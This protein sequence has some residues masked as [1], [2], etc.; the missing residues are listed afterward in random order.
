MDPAGERLAEWVRRNGGYIHP[1]L[2]V[3]INAPTGSRGVVARADIPAD[4]WW[5]DLP[6]GLRDDDDADGADEIDDDGSGVDGPSPA[7]TPR[8]A[9]GSGDHDDG[10]DPSTS[11]S[12]SAAAVPLPPRPT[13]PTPGTGRRRRQAPLVAVPEALYLSNALLDTG[14]YR[15]LLRPCRGVANSLPAHLQLALVL[16][17]EAEAGPRSFWA[18]Y[19]DVLRDTAP[20]CGW[21]A[22]KDEAERCLAAAGVPTRDRERE[23]AA[24]AAEAA[25]SAAAA[26]AGL[27]GTRI[28]GPDDQSAPV[29]MLPEDYASLAGGP[30]ASLM[31]GDHDVDGGGGQSEMESED[32]SSTFSG[33]RSLLARSLRRILAAVE[34][35]DGT[36]EVSE[37]GDGTEATGDTVAEPAAE[38]IP[39]E[40]AGE[41]AL[42]DDWLLVPPSTSS[43]SPTPPDSIDDEGAPEWETRW[44]DARRAIDGQVDLLR[45]GWGRDLGLSR[46]RLRWALGHVL[47][48]CFGDDDLV[49][50]AP[51]LDLLNH[52]RLAP[53]PQPRELG[54]GGSRGSDSAVS[55]R[56]GRAVPPA[57]LEDGG[58]L[59]VEV[60]ARWGGVPR[61]L[62]EGEELCISYVA[63]TDAVTAYINFGFVPEECRPRRTD[64]RD[65]DGGE[66][67][68]KGGKKGGKGSKDK[69][70]KTS[71]SNKVK[72]L[73]TGARDD[74]EELAL[75]SVDEEFAGQWGEATG[76][77]LP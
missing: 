67:G 38:T 59:C 72:E 28:D 13:S 17:I 76:P 18:D 14:P 26:A 41:P 54:S 7:T 34:G 50:L 62:D 10:E 22:P 53:A 32:G 66:G 33:V 71:K 65:P 1:S 51:Y 46:A 5:D 35:G 31:R 63:R 56:G 68:G 42:I 12:A 4:G 27:V 60:P 44:R 30:Y 58:P 23:A 39:A 16:A 6:P 49:G 2:C 11:T 48:R 19:V 45:K 3:A 69:L 29:E 25:E 57:Y 43:S 21:D 37:G 64:R 36:A 8:G 20:P 55:P 47:S 40:D 24:A 70:K 75:A 15:K 52:S 61:G 74:D 77:S 9:A 73:L